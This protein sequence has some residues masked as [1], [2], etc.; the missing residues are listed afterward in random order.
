MAPR[1]QGWQ[2]SPKMSLRPVLLALLSKEPNSGY[3]VGRLFRRQLSHLWDARLQQIYGELAKLEVEGL[4]QFESIELPNRP[5]KKVYSL[6]QAG[7]QALDVWLAERPA[8]VA[9]KDDLM[10]RLYCLER[11]P[12][13]VAIRRLEERRDEY[14]SEVREL[15]R[16]LVEIPRTDPAQLGHLLT[17]EAALSRAEGEA[18]WCARA[19]SCLRDGGQELSGLEERSVESG[20]GATLRAAGA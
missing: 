2:G 10:V 4:V 7:Q 15:R 14:E 20:R 11:M 16:K 13:E 5:A 3:G 18:A 1:W 12:Q 17:L 6:T 8:S 19:L 9:C